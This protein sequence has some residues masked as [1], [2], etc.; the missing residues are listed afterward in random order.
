MAD[1]PATTPA[2]GSVEEAAQALMARLTDTSDTQTPPDSPAA[3]AAP[4]DQPALEAAPEPEA[5]TETPDTPA[6][7]ETPVY[8]VRVEGEDLEVPLDELIKG[9]S[10]TADYTRKTQAVAEVRKQAEAEAQAV[11]EARNQYAGLLDQVQTALQALT[12]QEPNWSELRA[13]LSPKDYA[14]AQDTWREQSRRLDA[15]KQE[16]ERVTRQQA[17]DA[18][19]QVQTF[20]RDEQDKLLNAV[21]D[22]RDPT[23]AQTERQQLLDYAKARG[24]AEDDLKQVHDHRLW[25]VLRDAARWHQANAKRPTAPAKPALKTA[26]PGSPQSKPKT[27]AADEAMAKL[28]KTGRQ[29]DAASALLAAMG[30]RL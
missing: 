9:Y 2:K 14:N 1:S 8:K 13:T 30:D 6:T 24:F 19:R 29:S 3:H 22:W 23:K 25:L 12:P 10:R 20:L 16:R 5:G 4:E 11:R 15:L 7:P 21:P 28:R 18:Q 27:A 17:E 26:S